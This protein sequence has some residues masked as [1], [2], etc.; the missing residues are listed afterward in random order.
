VAL[1]P[2]G[3]AQWLVERAM[4]AENK[5]NVPDKKHFNN[6]ADYG[7]E[8]EE[9]RTPGDNETEHC[10]R[11][12][13]EESPTQVVEA[14]FPK[15]SL[16]HQVSSCEPPQ[17]N[18]LRCAKTLL[19]QFR[20]LPPSSA[21]IPPNENR[22]WVI[23]SPKTLLSKIGIASGSCSQPGGDPILFDRNTAS[24]PG[25]H[26]PLVLDMVRD[27]VKNRLLNVLGFASIFCSVILIL[28]SFIFVSPQAAIPSNVCPFFLTFFF[29]S[30]S[31]L[32][33]LSI[34]PHVFIW[35]RSARALLTVPSLSDCCGPTASVA[36]P[37]HKLPA[38][39]HRPCTSSLAALLHDRRPA[40]HRHQRL[41]HKKPGN[42][43]LGI[44][45]NPFLH[46]RLTVCARGANLCQKRRLC[47]WLK[48]LV[49]ILISSFLT[50][51]SP[52]SHLV[53]LPRHPSF[54]RPTACL[55]LWA[56]GSLLLLQRNHL[57][58][59]TLPP[60]PTAM[61][62]FQ[63]LFLPCARRLALELSLS[64]AAACPATLQCPWTFLSNRPSFPYCLCLLHHQQF[65][66]PLE[67][68]SHCSPLSSFAVPSLSSTSVSR[69]LIRSLLLFLSRWSPMPPWT[70]TKW[71]NSQATSP[72]KAI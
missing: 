46:R 33:F 59:A 65:L 3:G 9:L 5:Q 61:A 16:L 12:S 52:Q 38:R 63:L 14:D 6:D 29:G 58:L 28:S 40:R 34:S 55:L 31:L 25:L 26:F 50:F 68:P 45:C 19:Q 47:R 53:T 69:Y 37:F 24:V 51:S 4:L 13:S 1:T 36:F 62:W 2:E 60:S 20:G 72:P 66:K 18:A 15:D 39:R 22:F 17:S 48:L 8:L 23:C 71:R 44:F 30:T 64:F 43:C 49:S 32:P 57:R 54:L 70:A 42:Y 10:S 21:L 56:A 27:N 67:R 41:T 11:S 35:F 7:H